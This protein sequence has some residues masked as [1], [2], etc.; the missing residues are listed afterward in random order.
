MAKGGVSTT[1]AN[2]T[3]QHNGVPKPTICERHD[4]TQAHQ[5]WIANTIPGISPFSQRAS[6]HRIAAIRL[7]GSSADERGDVAVQVQ[8]GVHLDGGFMLS[9]FGPG[10]QGQAEID[11]GGV[12]RV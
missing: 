5:A 10:K 9:E 11:G 4:G 1:K 3:A 7:L 2:L 6:R 12:Q 8:Q